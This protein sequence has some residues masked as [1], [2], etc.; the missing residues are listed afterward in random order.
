MAKGWKWNKELYKNRIQ[1][2]P[3]SDQFE[4]LR[5]KMILRNLNPYKKDDIY[6]YLANICSDAIQREEEL[7]VTTVRNWQYLKGGPGDKRIIKLL[8]ATLKAKF[9]T[10]EESEETKQS[11]EEVILIKEHIIKSIQTQTDSSEAE[12]ENHVEKQTTATAEFT[13]KYSDFVK[14]KLFEVH[15]AILNYIARL[16]YETDL[17]VLRE[18]YNSL[19]SLLITT[20]IAIPIEIYEVLHYFLTDYLDRRFFSGGSY[21]A[22]PDLIIDFEKLDLNTWLGSEQANLDIEDEN[23]EETLKSLLFYQIS[24]VYTEIA[25]VCLQ[26]ILLN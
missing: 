11:M 14:T 15:E 9:C 22:A 23:Y 24:D 25:S 6:Y 4:E 10:T 19:Y 1:D 8:E 26:P 13:L 18:D 20:R 12:T 2:I 3:I 7:T 16:S 5:N 17:N 21:G